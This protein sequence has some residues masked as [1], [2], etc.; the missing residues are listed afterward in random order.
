MDG[1]LVILQLVNEANQLRYPLTIDNVSLNL[2]TVKDKDSPR[3]TG[4]VIDAVPDK[5]YK[6]K[7]EVLFD[8]HDLPVLFEEAGMTPSIRSNET[9][10]AEL[11][12][13]LLNIKYGFYLEAQDL[14]EIKI[15]EFEELE[16]TQSIEIVVKE[17]SWNWV[18]TIT[19][20]T[21]FGNPLI[22]SVVI[23]RLMP[24]LVHPVDLK[25][26]GDKASGYMSSWGMDF[27]AYLKKLVIDRGTGKWKNMDEVMAVGA[28]A[29]IPAWPNGQVL[30]YPTS[31]V[32][33]AN[34]KFERVL[35]QAYAGANVLG[36]IY[37]HYDLNW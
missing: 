20:E 9:I 7:V 19:L 4:I 5:G 28:L 37:F 27:T 11:I 26:L 12:I 22:E 16:T 25:I 13:E 8:R 29:G 17:N 30:D 35:V 6:G 34:P 24:V 1:R 10:T 36:P 33:N 14:E 23:V 3:N 32:A 21:T 31:A 2:P 18:G 15:P